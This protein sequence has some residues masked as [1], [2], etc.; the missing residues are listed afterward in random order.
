[1]MQH[2]MRVRQRRLILVCSIIYIIYTVKAYRNFAKFV[3][4]IWL[5]GCVVTLSVVLLYYVG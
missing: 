5:I 2:V 4:E 1:M 3:L